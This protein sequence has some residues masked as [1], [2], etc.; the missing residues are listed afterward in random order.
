MVCI[1]N[2]NDGACNYGVSIGLIAFFASTAFL[3]ADAYLPLMSSAQER[4]RLV[5][6]DL[7]FSGETERNRIAAQKMK[8]S[9]NFKATD[10]AS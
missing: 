1:F 9:K 5:I 3:F 8:M 6:A 4:R 2:H 10:L 7:G